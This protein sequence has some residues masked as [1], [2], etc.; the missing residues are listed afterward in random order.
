MR[1]C[2]GCFGAGLHTT[3]TGI[4]ATRNDYQPVNRDP[5]KTDAGQREAAARRFRHFEQHGVAAD[6]AML[7]SR[8]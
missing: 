7:A 5:A 2:R 8:R 4:A 3:T 6:I 1:L